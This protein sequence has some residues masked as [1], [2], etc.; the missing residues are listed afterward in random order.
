MANFLSTTGTYLYYP[1]LKEEIKKNK[2]LLLLILS[3]CFKLDPF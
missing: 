3:L 2:S 1:V